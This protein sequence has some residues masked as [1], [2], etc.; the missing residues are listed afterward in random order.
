MK[1]KFILVKIAKFW[2]E[3]AFFVNHFGKMKAS[4][5]FGPSQPVEKSGSVR[6]NYK[7]PNGSESLKM[8]NFFKSFYCLIAVCGAFCIWYQNR[9]RDLVKYLRKLVVTLVSNVMKLGMVLLLRLR[10]VSG[11]KSRYSMINHFNFKWNVFNATFE[12]KLKTLKLQN[13]K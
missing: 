2:L 3:I 9:V 5:Y 6:F 12:V 7:H 11:G 8:F 10:V 13:G 1:T 4:F